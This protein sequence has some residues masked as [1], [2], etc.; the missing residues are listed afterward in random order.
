MRHGLQSHE[1]VTVH[2]LALIEALDPWVKANRK[3]CGLDKRPSMILV[4]VFGVPLAFDL[5]VISM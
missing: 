5:V 1:F 3:V 4:A 2:L